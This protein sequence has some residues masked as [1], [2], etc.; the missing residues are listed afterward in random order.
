MNNPECKVCGS[1]DVEIAYKSVS[2]Y[3]TGDHFEIWRCN[4]CSAAITWPLPDNFSPYYPEK[5]RRYPPIIIKT[6]KYLYRQR[7]KKWS[8]KFLEPGTAFEMGC[9]DGL[10]LSSLRD[11]GWKVFGNERTPQSAYF[12][13][14]KLGLPIFVGGVGAL[15]LVS[16]FDLIFLFQVLEHLEDPSGTIQNLSLILK[17]HGKLI[18]GVPNFSS[19]QSRFSGKN[20]F[21]LDPPRHL[22]H[23][24]LPALEILAER[25][26]LKIDSVHYVSLE[27]DPFGWIQ[28]ILNI[29]DRQN[30]RLSRLLMGIDPPDPINLFHLLLSIILGIICVP[31]A[32][33]SWLIGQGGLIEVTASLKQ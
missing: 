3:I 13:R 32:A 9:G 6:L 7:V 25:S 31:L 5:Y 17:P 22:Y 27:H 26:G 29:L 1:S 4:H 15:P 23:Y 12:A 8:S 20:W 19:W 14:H 28:S 18:I 24:S 11:L 2:D 33:I 21:H 30:N 10:M 16:S